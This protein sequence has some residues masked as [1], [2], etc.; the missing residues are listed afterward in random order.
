MANLTEVLICLS[1]IVLS[2]RIC[3]IH[4]TE[5]MDVLVRLY[6]EAGYSYKRILRFLASLHDVSISLRT[7]KRLLHWMGLKRRPGSDL[8]RV[9]GAVQVFGA[10]CTHSIP[11]CHIYKHSMYME[12]L[13]KRR[14]GV[15]YLSAFVYNYDRN[16]ERFSLSWRVLNQ[17]FQEN[18]S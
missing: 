9:V 16:S 7:L 5:L 6:F 8:R 3:D 11:S 12:P 2:M 18:Y 14:F 4:V 1:S 13:N 15:S 17:R 10:S